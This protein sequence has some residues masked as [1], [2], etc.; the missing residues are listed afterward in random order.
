VASVRVLS[1]YRLAVSFVDGTRGEAELGPLIL[2]EGAG[3]FEQLRDP[4]VFA[5]AFV[6]DGAV[7]WPNGLDLAPDAMYD[8]IRDGGVF[9]PE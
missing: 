4:E 5:Q 6:D 9:T 7:A 2:S 1:A 8:V 3:V